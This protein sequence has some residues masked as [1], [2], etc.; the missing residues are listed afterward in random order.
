MNTFT[1]YRLLKSA[2]APK[3]GASRSKEA[4]SLGYRVL[5]DT[6]Q[7][8]YIALISNSSSGCFSKELI[9]TT[10]LKARLAGAPGEAFPSKVLVGAFKSRN[11][12]QPGFVCCLLRAEGLIQ[13]A[14]I[15]HLHVLAKNWDT[16][17]AAMLALL[18]GEPVEVPDEDA[19]LA[20]N[21]DIEPG[22]EHRKG[23]KAKAP[24]GKV[25]VVT[26]DETGDDHADRDQPA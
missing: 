19:V 14:E 18:P 25:E 17:E 26:I 5:A 21:P 13:P 23:K 20:P 2:E 15:P 11:A 8:L 10:Q 7:N 16:W 12:N 22:P 4:G 24:S 6:D 1:T 3:S 9:P